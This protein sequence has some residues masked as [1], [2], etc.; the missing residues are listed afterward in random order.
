M[1]Y[2]L[3][4]PAIG[5]TQSYFIS[6]LVNVTIKPNDDAAYGQLTIA[7]RRSGAKLHNLKGGG[8]SRKAEAEV[9]PGMNPFHCGRWS[10]EKGNS[11]H[12]IDRLT[13]CVGLRDEG[14]CQDAG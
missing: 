2:T 9:F 8:G 14:V 4:I 10:H 11:C 12:L 5:T 1:E 3:A 7:G 13:V 6:I